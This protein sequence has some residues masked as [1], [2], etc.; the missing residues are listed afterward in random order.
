MPDSLVN[1]LFAL[2][3]AAIA[4][5]VGYVSAIGAAVR[6]EKNQAVIEFQSSFQPTLA[7]IDPH[8]GLGINDF[9]F[10]GQTLVKILEEDFPRHV[11]AYQKFRQ[12]LPTEKQLAFD[13][14]WSEYCHH[15]SDDGRVYVHFKKYFNP[16]TYADHL[17]ERNVAIRN[18][19]TLLSFAELNHKSPFESGL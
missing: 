10:P 19:T 8:L 5:L 14:A 3:G 9:S 15:K 1:G 17:N 6:K 7:K 4:G 12:F 11:M 18:L 13:D 16:A 2:L